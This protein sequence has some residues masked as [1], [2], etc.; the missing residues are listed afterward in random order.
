VL[1]AVAVLGPAVVELL[2]RTSQT[3]V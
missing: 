1:V 3:E 2:S